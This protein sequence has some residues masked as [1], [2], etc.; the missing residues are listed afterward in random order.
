MIPEYKTI[1]YATDL[2]PNAAFALRHAVG[3]A[4]KYDAKV[5]VLHVLAEVDAS[6]VNYVATV[7][8]E[9]RLADFELQH[10]KEVANEIKK[11]IESFASAELNSDSKDLDRIV[12]I[13][14]RHGN[15][16]AEILEEADECDADLIVVGSHGKGALSY[17]FLGSV[18]EK[19]LR[20]SHRPVLVVPLEK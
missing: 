9:D 17:A 18:A 4:R 19:L 7:M 13:E 11:R 20:K 5:K 12:A 3:I 8:G 15:P 1:L 2:T 10:H 14:A 6:V 16:I